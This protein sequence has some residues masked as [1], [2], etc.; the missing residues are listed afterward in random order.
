ME[1]LRKAGIYFDVTVNGPKDDPKEQA[2]DIFWFRKKDDQALIGR[3]LRE[4]LPK[5]AK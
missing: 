5:Q 1:A 3:I 2:W 4:A